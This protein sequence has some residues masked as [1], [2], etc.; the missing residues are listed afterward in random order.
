ME[1][2]AQVDAAINAAV[3]SAADE[4]VTGVG[5]MDPMNRIS[6]LAQGREAITKAM[7]GVN[8]STSTASTT[9]STNGTAGSSEPADIELA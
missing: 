8:P 2:M 1:S 7:D 5:K 4:L 3:A 6:T 9:A